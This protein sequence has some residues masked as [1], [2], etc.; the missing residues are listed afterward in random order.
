MTSSEE[1]LEAH[2]IENSIEPE[3]VVHIVPTSHISE[4]SS[5]KV[6]QVIENVNPDVIAVELDKN[7]LQKLK[8]RENG[9]VSNM[10]FKDVLFDESIPLK[11]K[12]LLYPF[13]KVQSLASSKVGIDI[14]GV[15]MLAG[16]NASEEKEIPLALVDQK[17]DRTVERFS[18]EV[19]ALH[20]SKMMVYFLISYIVL[21]LSSSNN[22]ND[23]LNPDNMDMDQLLDEMETTLPTFK[24]VFIDERNEVISNHMI[25]LLDTDSGELKDISSIVLVIGAGHEPG[26]KEKLHK[27]SINTI[28]H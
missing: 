7:R 2:I 17:L 1:S 28:S 13:S 23:L 26:I 27:N 4:N 12:L 25:K 21:K 3:G 24:K 15:D 19:S 20:L 6:I 11:G 5:R 8:E 22:S 9:N 10:N 18:S 14:T 16:V